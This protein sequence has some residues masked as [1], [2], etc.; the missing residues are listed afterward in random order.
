MQ[1]DNT[2]EWDQTFEG[3]VIMWTTDTT[4]Y[5]IKFKELTTAQISALSTPPDWVWLVDSTTGQFKVKIWWSFE[6]MGAWATTPNASESVT[7]KTRLSDQTQT[8]EQTTT[9]W[10]DPLVPTNVTINPN[11]I[12]ATTPATGDKVSFSDIS[13]SNK[14]RS[15]TIKSLLTTSRFWDGS[16]GVISAWALTITWSNNTYITKQYTTFAPWANTVTI[17]PTNCILHIKVQGDCDLT[18]T[19]FSFSGKWAAWWAAWSWGWGAT[20]NWTSWSDWIATFV[21]VLWWAW[22]WV[23]TTNAPAY[24]VDFWADW[25]LAWCG[26]GWWGWQ[27]DDGYS[28]NTMMIMTK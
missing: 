17:T 5:G 22:W 2:F 4:K 19:T 9:E 16:D 21:R 27:Y 26:S 24:I 8:E 1:A 7:G 10:G 3:N 18:G 11:N 14:L 13:N 25:I 15:T 12:T 20:V 28:D 6:S 23:T